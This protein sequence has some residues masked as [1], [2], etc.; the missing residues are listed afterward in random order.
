MRFGVGGLEIFGGRV[1][2]SLPAGGVVQA[3]L[4]HLNGVQTSTPGAGKNA[5]FIFSLVVVILGNTQ[6]GEA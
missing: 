1:Y 5:N 3:N 2:P 4:A 6:K